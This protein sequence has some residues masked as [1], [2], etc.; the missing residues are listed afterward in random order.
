MAAAPVGQATADVEGSVPV[1]V[2]IGA[3]FE[4][5]ACGL[6]GGTE[7]FPVPAFGIDFNQTAA[8]SNLQ[9]LIFVPKGDEASEDDGCSGEHGDEE[10]ED[11]SASTPGRGAGDAG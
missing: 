5:E 10:E 11:L 7:V 9:V 2:P 3:G 6:E 8:S 1:P 4:V